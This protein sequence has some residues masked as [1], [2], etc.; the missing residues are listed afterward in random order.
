VLEGVSVV[1]F[2]GAEDGAGTGAVN[3]ELDLFVLCIEGGDS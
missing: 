2:F 3:H 1:V